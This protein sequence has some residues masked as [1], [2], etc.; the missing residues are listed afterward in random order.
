LPAAR[1]AR[2]VRF[3]PYEADLSSGELHKGGSKLRIQPQP[4][5]LLS[6]LLR[7]HGEVVTRQEL[8]QALWP[9]DTYVEFN[10]SLNAAIKKLRRTIMDDPRRPR[11]IETL[12]RTGYRFSFPVEWVHEP[13]RPSLGGPVAVAAPASAAHR[14]RGDD[15]SVGDSGHRVWPSAKA[16][17]WDA[18][19]R[20][21]TPGRVLT[22]A[23]AVALLAV[24]YL[25]WIA[26]EP[27]LP[28]R[29][30]AIQP[31]AGITDFGGSISPDGLHVVYAVLSE[32]RRRL[33][34]RSLDSESAR[35]LPGTAG[36]MG[37]FWAP[38]SLSVGFATDTELRAVTLDGEEPVTLCKLPESDVPFGGGTW[39]GDG[40]R[41]VFSSGELLYE[42]PAAGGQAKLLFER[43]SFRSNY[44]HPHFLPGGSS[45]ALVYTAAVSPFDQMLA[46]LDLETGENRT[47]GPGS[48]PVYSSLDGH[49]VYGP[50]NSEGEGLM[51]IPFSL[52]TL[53]ATG[54]AFLIT[55]RGVEPSVSKDG[56]LVYLERPRNLVQLVR[57][58]RQGVVGETIGQPQLGLRMPALS[59]RQRSIAVTSQDSGTSDIW[60]VDA[61]NGGAT[62]LTFEP[63]IDDEAGWSPDG[64]QVIFSRQGRSGEGSSVLS[65]PVSGDGEAAVIVSA[66]GR[67]ANPEWSPDGG[68]LTY[69][70]YSGGPRSDIRFLEF[71]DGAPSQPK[72]FLGTAANEHSAK[73]FPLGERYIAYVS[74]QTGRDEIY[75]AQFPDATEIQKASL[76]GGRRARWRGDGGELYYIEGTTLVAVPVSVT[77]KG[78]RLGRPQRLFETRDLGAAGYAPS[79]DGRSF[80]TVSPA[81]SAVPAAPALHIVENWNKEHQEVNH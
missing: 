25:H 3:G 14:E 60:L 20:S 69:S 37:G 18:A 33:M 9:D 44:S 81:A 38:D 22:W 26:P 57:R 40:L 41:I 39:S 17:V 55:D 74:N 42:V 67:L 75:L 66:Q 30:F 31:G 46:V 45:N 27:Q 5:N 13:A 2:K 12:P 62:R 78:L 8:Q 51:A 54:R 59:R 68:Y 61:T 11:Y 43:D 70:D 10:A 71:H 21:L 73:F 56:I 50:S 79:A 65:K 28:V 63:G 23:L 16:P 35:E 76:N 36:A 1:W 6:L 72:T 4:F 53:A 32:G 49:L 77:S 19:R 15:R 7:R 29:R 58:D 64:S 48:A 34:L 47:V 24:A 52:D 80:I